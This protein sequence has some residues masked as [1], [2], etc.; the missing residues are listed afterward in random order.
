MRLKKAIVLCVLLVLSVGRV[1]AS[2][3]QWQVAATFPDWLGRTDDTLAMNNMISFQFWH[4]QGS[5]TVSPSRNTQTFRLFLNGE[6]LDTSGMLGGKTYTISIA[7]Y[8]K[9]GTNT[10]HVSG[11][12]P[13]GARVKVMIPYPEVL[14]GTLEDSGINPKSLELISDIISQDIAM[15]FTSAQLAVIRHGRLVCESSWGKLD[16]SNPDS[17]LADSRTMYDLAS[18][19]KMFGLNY[20]VQKL[21]T[22]GKLDLDSRVH[23]ILGN[24]YLNATLKLRYHKGTKA[25]PQEMRKWKA[26]IRVRDLLNHQAGYPPEMQYQNASYDIQAMNPDVKAV[27]VLKA[28]SR[29]DTLQSLMKTPLMYEPGTNRVYS[30][31]DYMLLCFIVERVSGKR[32]DEYLRE[33]FTRQ[34]GL[35]R[36]SYNPLMNGYSK[37][38]CAATE[39]HGNTYDGEINFPGIRRYTLQGEVH[40]GKAWYSMEGV[41]GHAGLFASA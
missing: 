32:L 5:I 12:K 39:L 25:S 29:K 41:S 23:E 13:S 9:D 24:D 3:E 19:T 31:I 16:S 22:E 21:V 14:P 1:W 11:I 20:A 17:P 38:D 7:D 35:S 10:L 15:G 18:V 27:N 4:G 36:V 34:L 6:Q 2:D 28:Y 40:D 30:D 37:N 33:N 26:R 8:V